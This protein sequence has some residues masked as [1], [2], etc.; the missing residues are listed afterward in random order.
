MAET[1]RAR[2]RPGSSSYRARPAGSDSRACGAL[3]L[4]RLAAGRGQPNTKPRSEEDR[5]FH[6]S[7]ATPAALCLSLGLGLAHRRLQMT[8]GLPQPIQDEFCGSDWFLNRLQFYRLQV[9]V[10][11]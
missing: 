7:R 11:L 2:N 10:C 8:E 9:Q 5:G 1:A 6:L 3:G 4:R